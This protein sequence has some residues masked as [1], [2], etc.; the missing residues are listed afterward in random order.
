MG[1]E[2]DWDDITTIIHSWIV[3]PRGSEFSIVLDPLYDS[4]TPVQLLGHSPEHSKY[5]DPLSQLPVSCFRNRIKLVVLV[6]GL[7]KLF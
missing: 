7:S 5:T 3:T 4:K 2:E 6:G 1:F